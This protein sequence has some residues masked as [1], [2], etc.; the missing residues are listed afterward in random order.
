MGFLFGLLMGAAASSASSSSPLEAS[1]TFAMCEKR[2]GIVI[3]DP[4]VD[5][6]WLCGQP[7]VNR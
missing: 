2:G 4:Q 5:R 1:T 7:K 6:G 3:I